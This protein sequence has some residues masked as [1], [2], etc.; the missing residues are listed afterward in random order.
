MAKKTKAKQTTKKDKRGVVRRRERRFV[1]QP[2]ANPALVRGLGAVAA[3]LLGAGLWA[4]FYGK[5]FAGDETLARVP[6]YLVAAGAVV[7]GVVLWIGTSSEPPV[8]VG[9]PGISVEKGELRRM[10]W[11]AIETITLDG[12]ALHLVVAGKD[13]AG[14]EWTFKIPTRAHPDAVGWIIK[15]AKDRVPRC[16]DIPDEQRNALPAAPEHAGLELQLDPLQ[17]VGKR[18]ARTGKII[19]YEPDAR[20]C[21]RCERVY[22]KNTVPK[23]C[24][25]RNSLAHLRPKGSTSDDD[26]GDDDEASSSS[27]VRAAE[28]AET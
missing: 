24:A 12:G 23:R 15:E 6:S 17:V 14:V 18:D 2:T 19:S 22:F 5:S 27:N 25:C 7:C 11:W 9:D 20:V 13:D 21:P 1:P 10:P 16:I 28:T 26:E 8:R 3:L 4:Y